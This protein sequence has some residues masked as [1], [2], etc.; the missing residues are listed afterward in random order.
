MSKFDELAD[1]ARQK[2]EALENGE[3]QAEIEKFERR[4]A[5]NTMRLQEIFEKSVSKEA[6]E[7]LHP[8]YI[9]DAIGKG[10][11]KLHVKETRFEIEINLDH[12]REN[13]NSIYVTTAG[14]EKRHIG[15]AYFKD[16]G[17]FEARLLTTLKSYLDNP[18]GHFA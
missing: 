6:L 10:A 15:T 17:K 16:S 13:T 11:I 7:E 12:Y 18:S 3:K 9:C 4:K 14:K 5:E 8:T 2:L 1:A